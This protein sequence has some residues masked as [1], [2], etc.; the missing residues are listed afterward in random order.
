MVKRISPGARL[1][2]FK[3]NLYIE[4]DDCK[5]WPYSTS[6]NGYGTFRLLGHSYYVHTL[7]C[8]A[9]NG[10]QPAG[11][12]AS[13]GPCHLPRCWNGFHLSWKSRV[14]DSLDRW[15]DGSVSHG[16]EWMNA[17][18]SQADVDDIRVQVAAGRRQSEMASLYGVG[19]PQIH[20][21]VH[22]KQWSPVEVLDRAPK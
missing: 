7:A 16:E 19:R 3:E 15:R 11:F 14:D 18:L 20:R 9:Y 1:K 21:I 5:I 2:Y 12:V 8:Q 22:H 6:G 13:H 4:T 17:K 10:P